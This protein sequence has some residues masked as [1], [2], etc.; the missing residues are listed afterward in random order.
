MNVFVLTTSWKND[1]CEDFDVRVF[2]D[3]DDAIEA[4]VNFRA[5]AIMCVG[6][7][8]LEEDSETSF[9]IYEDGYAAYNRVWAHI[10]D[11]RV[12]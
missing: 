2:A 5:E 1:G 3:K 9:D 8:H 7:W 12:K 11:C 4:L 6:D 10:T